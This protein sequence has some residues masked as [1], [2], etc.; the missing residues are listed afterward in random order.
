MA[1]GIKTGGREK[2]TPNKLTT[3][4]RASLKNILADE[5][6]AIP[7]TL[8]ELDPKERL[9]LIIKLMPFAMPKVQNVNYNNG[10]PLNLD[11]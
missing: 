10:E 6:K 5:I 8:T 4:L 3:E 11:W 7:Q 1:K 9:E 2:G